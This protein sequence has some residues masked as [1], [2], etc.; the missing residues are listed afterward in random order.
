MLIKMQGVFKIL[1]AIDANLSGIIWVCSQGGNLIIF[2]R[3]KDGY[4]CD[5]TLCVLT[6]LEKGV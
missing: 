4:G 5:V 6:V 1:L 3:E 2:L